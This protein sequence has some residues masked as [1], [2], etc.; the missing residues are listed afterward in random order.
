MAV[1]RGPTHT[2]ESANEL[3]AALLG[4][5]DVIGQSIRDALPELAG[6][7]YLENLDRTYATGES[8]RGSGASFILHRSQNELPEQRYIDFVFEPIRD[9]RGRPFGI[10]V[11]GHDVTTAIRA[12]VHVREIER[13]ARATIDALSESIAVLD[14]DG[15]VIA[16]NR[17][18]SALAAERHD[19]LLASRE[20]VDYLA[21]CDEAAR[22]GDVDA[23]RIATL[24]RSV[25]SR[26]EAEPSIEYTRLNPSGPRW[27]ALRAM[28]FP[29]DGPVRV[30]LAN[31]EITDRK[32]YEFRIEYLA[33]HDALTGLP[34]RNLLSDRAA[35][36][37]DRARS[38]SSG[39]ALL[40]IDLDDFRHVKDAY[41]H[42]IGDA[43]ISA[44]AQRIARLARPGD[45]VARVGSDE[46]VMVLNDV[47]DL[48]TEAARMARS[49]LDD[50]THPFA[51]DEHELT[52]SASVGISLFPADGN[53]LQA[54]LKNAEVA[55][56][57][58]KSLG[59]GGYQ[60]CSP[61]MSARANERVII[62]G[63]LRRALRLGQLE[64][65]YQP[66]VEMSTGTLVGIEAL[67]RWHHPQL[68]WLSPAR[69]IPVAEKTGLIG[70]IGRFVLLEACRQARAWQRDGVASASIAVN[71]TAS[72]LRDPDFPGLV[73][74][75]I[76]ETGIEPGN[77]EL[78]ITEGMMMEVTDSLLARLDS[79][80]KL[81]VRLSV[82]DFG[83]GYS[84]LV[85]LR[86][87]PLDRLKIDRSFIATID[88][89]E[90]SRSIV[91]AILG[92]GQSFGLD[93]VAEG[94]ETAEQAGLLA[95][96]GCSQAQ[97]F[98]YAVP[99]PGE[100]LAQWILGRGDQKRHAASSGRSPRLV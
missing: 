18:W 78:E 15:K 52:L 66:Q 60:F 89:D 45:T 2:I 47:G 70:P 48:S 81:G 5:R 77:L 80:K 64:L 40:A 33:T 20:G 9:R 87:F 100:E 50:L 61:E 63:E 94:V 30:A 37:I 92:L 24:V 83:T 93:V 67:A 55:V 97:G 84:N 96:L 91:R 28:R 41:G 27:F 49:I 79:L 62:E 29:G 68:G 54:L 10:F 43:A 22:N 6:Q 72:Q 35:Q 12:D 32:T 59:G 14:F 90:G 88:T 38:S 98:F 85:Y 65:H 95:E 4:G 19:A 74:D 7:G 23:G 69:F 82:D 58:A 16:V 13:L 3:F 86:T 51:I 26:D 46:F 1:L 11:E 56:D 34:N 25:L 36:I 57:R 44:C 42:A 21:A 99:M 17:A 39:L 8:Y 71:I 73:E 76:A 75:T 53:D 31:Q